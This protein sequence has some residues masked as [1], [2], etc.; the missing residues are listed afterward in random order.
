MAIRPAV[1]QIEQRQHQA[2]VEPLA[3]HIQMQLPQQAADQLLAQPIILFTHLVHY[4]GADKERH[5]KASGWVGQF[6]CKPGR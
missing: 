4:S 2:G 5:G 3:H 6:W 1:H